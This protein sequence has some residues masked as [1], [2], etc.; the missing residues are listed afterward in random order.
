MFLTK[1]KK[2]QLLNFESRRIKTTGFFGEELE[3]NAIK[4]TFISDYE[5][6][7]PIFGVTT[8]VIEKTT[9]GYTICIIGYGHVKPLPDADLMEASKN[10]KERLRSTAGASVAIYLY[11]DKKFKLIQVEY[12]YLYNGSKGCI[13]AD[14]ARAMSYEY[15]PEDKNPDI[16]MSTKYID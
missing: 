2:E 4:N 1:K 9:D 16:L 6:L 7:V 11:L 14:Y 12:H 3:L 8:D 5:I 15:D 10:L 13:N